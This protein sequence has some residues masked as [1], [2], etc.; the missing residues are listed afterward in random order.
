MLFM[1]S[2]TVSLIRQILLLTL[3]VQK[4]KSF[5]LHGGFTP[6]TRGY[7]PGPRWGLHP[8]TPIIGS[9]YRTRH[10]PRQLFEIPP[11]LGVLELCLNVEV[12]SL[13]SV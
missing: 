2:A 12:S 8:Q 5:Q 3:D 10:N 1:E 6:L 4:T 11:H 7:A 9:C 13:C